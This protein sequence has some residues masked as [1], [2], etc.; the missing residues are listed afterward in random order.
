MNQE[1]VAFTRSTA[2]YKDACT[3][4]N[5]ELFYLALGLTSEAG[6]VAG[7]IKRI[8][9]EGAWNTQSREKLTFELGDVL[10]Y[11]TRLCDSLGLELDDIA[12]LN[13]DKLS[14][15]KERGTIMGYGDK[16]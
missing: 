9:R 6:E 13:M 16:R 1:Y 3:G 5:E 11:L 2:V 4:K 10:W 7:V 8:L 12:E 14:S 15:R